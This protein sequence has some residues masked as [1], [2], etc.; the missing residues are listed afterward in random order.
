MALNGE[1]RLWR[2]LGEVPEGTKVLGVKVA[3]PRVVIETPD[4]EQTPALMNSTTVFVEVSEQEWEAI[5][6]DVAKA[7]AKAKELGP[8]LAAHFGGYVRRWHD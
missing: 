3:V 7:N 1:R 2:T 4:G 8:W 6:G 5:G